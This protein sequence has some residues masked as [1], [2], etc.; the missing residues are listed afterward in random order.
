MGNEETAS[1]IPPPS[2]AP[3]Q[4]FRLDRAHSDVDPSDSRFQFAMLIFQGDPEAFHD[5]YFDPCIG[6]TQT[7][8]VNGLPSMDLPIQLSC[9][10]HPLSLSTQ[11]KQV[12]L[13]S[14]SVAALLLLTRRF[15]RAPGPPRS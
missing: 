6:V 9:A 1:P 14:A 3:L 7:M 12:A 4:F 8:R 5:S 11:L 13:D 2:G 10:V 15:L